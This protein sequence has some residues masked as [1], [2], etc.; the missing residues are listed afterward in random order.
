MIYFASPH[1][2]YQRNCMCN[3]AWMVMFTIIIWRQKTLLSPIPSLRHAFPKIRSAENRKGALKVNTEERVGIVLVHC[4]MS[5]SLFWQ[6]LRV[7][8][9]VQ[10]D[11]S[12]CCPLMGSGLS[13]KGLVHYKFM[14]SAFETWNNTSGHMMP[15][16]W[17]RL[18]Q[19]TLMHLLIEWVYQQNCIFNWN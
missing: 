11:Q 2:L 5:Y 17:V 6:K 19:S 4:L 8:S 3:I 7:D 18:A 9:S 15:H 1:N 10:W 14:L 13:P 12:T 16:S